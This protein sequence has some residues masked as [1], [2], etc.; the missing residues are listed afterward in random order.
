MVGRNRLIEADQSAPVYIEL[1][2]LLIKTLGPE[3]LLRSA[4]ADVDGILEA[5]IYGSW[6]DPARRSPADI[7][8]LVVG[9]PEVGAVYD[10]VS[11]VESEIGRPVNVTIRSPAEWDE[12]DGA[13]ERA[14]KSGSRIDL[15]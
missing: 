1:R 10:A 12:A 3:P 13:F 15:T 11:A 5:F 9:E 2:G 4:L 14:V 6:A 7:D 8:V